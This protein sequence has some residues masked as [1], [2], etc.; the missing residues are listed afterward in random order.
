MA[1][2]IVFFPLDVTY[3][4]EN[5]KAVIYLFGRT[6][7]GKQI[8]VVDENFE[9]YFYVIPKKGKNA[10]EK[11][12][13]IRV[14]RNK[15][16]SEVVRTEKVKK[17]FLGKDVEAIKVYVRLPR[18]VPVIRE[19]IKD[20]E[21]LESVNEYDIRFK[22]RYLIDRGITPLLAAEAVGE[23]VKY[24]SRVPVLKADKI[25]Q[26]G[27]TS[28]EEPRVLAFD[29]ETYNPDGKNIE[30]EKNPIIMLSFYGARYKK[31]ITW[32]RF[33]T[34]LEYIEFVKSEAELIERFKGVIN[35]YKPDI[36][37]GYFS[38][39][40]DLPYIKTRADKYK[41]KL[42]IG[43]DFSELKVNKTRK[44]SS[45]ITG[46]NHLDIFKF[47]RKIIGPT[48]DT[49]ALNLNAV[50]AELLKEKKLEVDLDK[51][52][53]AWD[54]K[55]GELENYCEYNLHDSFLSFKLAERM[56]PNIV[57]MVKIVGMVI[58]E[59][60]RMGFSQL[61]E[62]Y[63][64]KQAVSFNQLAPELPHH[65]ELRK[66]QMQTFKGGFVYE[67][68]P[69][70]YK[71]IVVFDYRSL[72]PTI[73]SSHN[74]DPGTLNCDCCEG[75][76]VAPTEGKKKYWFCAKKKGFLPTLI[77]DIITR[78]MRVREIMKDK[79]TPLMEARSL[80]LKLLANSFYGYLGF[81]MSRWY[82]L[83]SAKSTTAYGRF[84]IHKVIDEAEKERFKVLY[85]DSLPFDRSVFVKTPR[86]DI[87]IMKIGE[88]YNKF[89]AGCETLSYTKDNKVRFMPIKRV[90]RHPFRGKG[91]LIKIITN[92]GATIVTNQHSIYTY[93]KK[94]K[95]THAGKLKKDDCLISLTNP[96]IE[97]K[98]KEGFIFDIAELNLGEFGDEL[99]LYKDNLIF[100][101][102][103]KG[104][105]PY[106]GKEYY[107]ATH[108]NLKHKERKQRIIKESHF[109]FVGA[110]NAKGGKIPRYW[111]L[112]KELA[113]ILGF[114]CAEGSVSNVKTKSGRKMLLSFGSQDIEVIRKVKSILDKK[115]CANLSIIRNFD[116][117]NKKYMYYYRVQRIPLV[118]LFKNGFCAGKGSEFKK[119]PFFIL[120]SEKNLREAFLRGYLDGDGNAFRD[121][122]YKTHFI[123]FST[124]SKE[125]AMGLDFLLKSIKSG[126][127]FFGKEV[128]HV[129]WQYRKDK[130]K[131]QTLR[132]QSAK[133]SKGNF[134]LAQIRRIE[135][136]P[137]EKYVYDLEVEG[138]HNFVDAEGMMLVHNTDSVFL[139]LD[140]KT[141]KEVDKFQEKIN[142]ELP[143]LMELEY[144][145]FY[146]TGI[147]VSA[148]I[149]R[150][151]A[152]KKYALLSEDGNL[153]IRGF[154]TVRR[155]WSSIAKDTQ[156]RI[157]GT[158]LK[159]QKPEK[160]LKYV[161]DVVKDLRENK[162]PL[163]EV[164]IHT[165][166]Q[167]EIDA[168]NAIGPHV[169]IASRMRK[170]G[171][172]VGPGS[173]IEFIITRTGKRVRDRAKLPDEVKQKDYDPD[174]Y[175]NN[176]V[177]PAVEKIFEVLGYTRE[178]L[179][180]SKGQDKL[181]KFF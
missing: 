13:K 17:H 127:N 76:K 51:L 158:I 98:Y 156:E 21:I 10:E 179:I 3:K 141:K 146:P 95:L 111:K 16:T 150:F 181:G 93:D 20:W 174:Y 2:K 55:H 80:S 97:V 47:I 178:D 154:E 91:Q 175:I 79:K 87:K 152:K 113:W 163:K 119:I 135:K 33:N 165:R 72:Y 161:R 9:P 64:L 139:T 7:D 170:K 48:M 114:Y 78:R 37:T 29:I 96:K 128:K 157:L 15:E 168:Y 162:I 176:Q 89:K 138:S 109:K 166:L 12:G 123:R 126:T 120:N 34:K 35:E 83:E 118:A 108:V 94:I 59:L 117:R 148:K 115:I 77:E 49:F 134:C 131:I 173:T 81:P 155:N 61:V 86:G 144:E 180:E 92:Y 149:G 100:P 132:L 56:M 53:E 85:S 36:L 39:E 121:K 103:K 60:A 110:T 44:T 30:P 107:L 84:Y 88:L 66:R 147:F 90:I 151:G 82:S 23:F 1:E 172:D 112:D 54:K 57:E 50:A 106:C 22:R 124:K 104:K 167:K 27:E 116:K 25:E 169:A 105:C 177:I 140:G 14:E 159:E 5:N 130:P 58:P 19:I 101:A 32:K 160:A 24:R 8:C 125:L 26:R 75:K 71:D 28:L 65:S 40:F 153:K 11:L 74:I 69:G 52:A 4:I 68:K 145:G 70:L 43:L 62:S 45:N 99:R 67:P 102:G 46:I 122:R 171:I 129:A 38:D 63:I 133:E 18:D 164:I 41:I 73:I 136:V 42:D 142:S 6:S 137:N 31:V 143:G